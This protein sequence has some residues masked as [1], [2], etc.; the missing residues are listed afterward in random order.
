M[1]ELYQMVQLHV[2]VKK[3]NGW[4]VWREKTLG[5]YVGEKEEKK[6][7]CQNKMPISHTKKV[8]Y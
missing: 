6:C 3:T 1:G 7:C 4:N 5:L 8:F 2:K